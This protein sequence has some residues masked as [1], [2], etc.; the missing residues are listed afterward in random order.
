MLVYACRGD[1]CA[2]RVRAHLHHVYGS[3]SLR[4][5]RTPTV[6]LH[7]GD[8]LSRTFVYRNDFSLEAIT[9]SLHGLDMFKVFIH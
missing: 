7:E 4:F 2:Y 1:L 5:L 6:E 8:K 9:A 3:L